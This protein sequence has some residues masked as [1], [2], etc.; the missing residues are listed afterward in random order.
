VNVTKDFIE[1]MKN[2]RVLLRGKNKYFLRPA[3][4]LTGV[5]S[6][7]VLSRRIYSSWGGKRMCWC[8]ASPPVRSN[9]LQQVPYLSDSKGDGSG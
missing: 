7:L 3:V 2:H 9:P 6:A 4:L 1:M 8:L 5:R